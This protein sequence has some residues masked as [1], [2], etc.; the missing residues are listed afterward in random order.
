MNIALMKEECKKLGNKY[1]HLQPIIQDLYEYTICE[2]EDGSPESHE[3]DLC[4]NSLKELE[5]KCLSR[6][7]SNE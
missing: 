3:V 6:L 7:R 5:Q 2:I 4:L 1:P